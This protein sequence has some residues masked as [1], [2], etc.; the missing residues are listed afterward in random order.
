MAQAVASARRAKNTTVE[1]LRGFEAH[2][3]K[4]GSS[5]PSGIHEVS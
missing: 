3:K 1:S 2:A 4:S 5:S